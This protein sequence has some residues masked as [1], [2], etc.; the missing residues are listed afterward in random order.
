MSEPFEDHKNRRIKEI[1]K[2]VF[3]FMGKKGK[4]E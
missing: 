2:R 1:H 4:K 3:E